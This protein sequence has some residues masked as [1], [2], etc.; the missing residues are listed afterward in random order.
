MTIDEIMG[1]QTAQPRFDMFLFSAFAGLGLTLAA[2]GIDCV[3]SYN[4]TQ[5][6]REIGVRM[7]LGAT[8]SDIL[9]GCC[10]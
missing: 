4:V 3:I 10:A 9:I 1:Y 6:V 5:R 2:I 8:R 7:A